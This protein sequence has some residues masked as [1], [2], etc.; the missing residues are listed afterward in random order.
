MTENRTNGDRRRKG[1][2]ITEDLM[3]TEDSIRTDA[4]RLAD[5][6]RTKATL[7]PDDPKVEGLSADAVKLAQRIER[8]T[9]A[10]LDLSRDPG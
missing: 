1:P 3:A 10:E 9:R 7:E 4:G 8:Q 2:A 6:E 5:L